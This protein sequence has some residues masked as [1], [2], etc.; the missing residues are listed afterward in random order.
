MAFIRWKKNKFGT[1][2][3]YLIHSYR[4]E[5]GKPKHKT[6]AYL[7]PE[8]ELS[9]ERLAELKEKHSE[10]EVDWD[11]IRPAARPA[12]I[13][14]L[15]AL[16]DDDV[17]KQLRQ[18][19]LDRG[20]SKKRMVAALLLAGAPPLADWHKDSINVRI[21]GAL[22][23]AWATGRKEEHYENPKAVLISFIRRVLAQ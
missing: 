6:L 20:L 21:Y 17:L 22:E 13:M 11:S 9:P 15:E 23:N 3:A 5:E 12:P 18:L 4:D 7:G 19:R 16:S 14:P 10:I 8:T 2:N 1:R